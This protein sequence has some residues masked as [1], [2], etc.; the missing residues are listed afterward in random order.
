MALNQL[1]KKKPDRELLVQ[2]AK[3]YGIR[4]LDPIYTCTIVILNKLDTVNELYNIREKLEEYYVPCKAKK[5]LY[6]LTPKKSITV[7]RQLLKTHSMKLISKERY[8]E[9]KKYLEYSIRESNS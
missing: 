7:L 2:V 8:T 4:E 1:F 5:Y 3:L 9:G 6:N